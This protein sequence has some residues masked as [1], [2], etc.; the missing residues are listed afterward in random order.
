LDDSGRNA[1]TQ[2]NLGPRCNTFV[3]G[4]AVAVAAL[5]AAGLH[6]GSARAAGEAVPTD[7]SAQVDEIVSSALATAQAPPSEA[8]ARATNLVNQAMA[9]ANSAAAEATARAAPL[10]PQTAG[11]EVPNSTAGSTELARPGRTPPARPRH[12]RARKRAHAAVPRPEAQTRTIAG[13]AAPYHGSALS[14]SPPTARSLPFSPKR[15]AKTSPRPERSAPPE[16]PRP[17]GPMPPRPDASSAGQSGG[18]NAPVPLLLAVVLGVLLVFGFQ[19]LPRLLPLLAFRKP[20]RIVLPS[21][22]PG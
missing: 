17:P 3:K 7:L 1:G 12:T 2:A 21:W 5:A 22:H 4:C 9:I 15:A 14:T 10:V 11:A 13:P 8:P 18:Q 20:R 16:H 6:V 19:F